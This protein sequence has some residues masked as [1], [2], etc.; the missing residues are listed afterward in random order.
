MAKAQLLGQSQEELEK[1]LEEEKKNDEKEYKALCNNLQ[2]ANEVEIRGLLEAQKSEID[3]MEIAHSMSFTST[4][5]HFQEEGQRHREAFLRQLEKEGAC[6]LSVGDV[7]LDLYHK[8]EEEAYLDSLERQIKMIYEKNIRDEKEKLN[9][10]I[11]SLS[12]D[13]DGEKERARVQSEHEK[14]IKTLTTLMEEE[15]QAK[16]AELK[17]CLEK[18]HQARCSVLRK[19]IDAGMQAIPIISARQVGLGN[20][21]KQH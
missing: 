6:K 7:L 10:I 4:E 9:E 17:M 16:K 8:T 14:S 12:F 2:S 18:A 1:I 15:M 3:E 19:R 11:S 20:T 5:G 13:E 21:L